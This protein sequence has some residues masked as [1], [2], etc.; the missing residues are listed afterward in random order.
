MAGDRLASSLILLAAA[1]LAA[2]G[3]F[4]PSLKVWPLSIVF[5][6]GW[7]IAYGRR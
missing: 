7:L 5:F 1:M 6:L 4:W 2:T 3:V